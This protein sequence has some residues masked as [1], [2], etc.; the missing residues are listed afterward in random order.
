LSL[1]GYFWDQNIVSF[2]VENHY[3]DRNTVHAY[4]TGLCQLCWIA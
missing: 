4:F 1:E 3:N 2:S